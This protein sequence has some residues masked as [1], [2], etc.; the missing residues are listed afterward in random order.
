MILYKS[1]VYKEKLFSSCSFEDSGFPTNPLIFT[2]FVSSISTG[3]SFSFI[4]DP[5]MLIILCL[6]L[7]GSNRKILL[8]SIFKLKYISTD[9]Q[10]ILLNCSIICLFS[11][12]SDF[13][14][15]A[16]VAGTLKNKFFIF[17]EVPSTQI[18]FS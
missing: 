1:S 17:I 2:K 7:D 9:L 18:Q 3:T 15:F 6:N 5:I 8:L 10:V 13:R 4:L 12:L 14:K 11:T 16:F